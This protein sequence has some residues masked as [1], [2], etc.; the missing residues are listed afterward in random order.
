MNT[1]TSISLLVLAALV[2]TLFTTPD[3]RAEPRRE[4]MPT[5]V[6]LGTVPSHTKHP[7]RHTPRH[8]MARPTGRTVCATPPHRH[9]A[10]SGAPQLRI[11]I[12]L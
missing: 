11:E 7:H 8:V 6:T 5:M 3:V 10:R 2:A 9:P 12:V 4:A 1:K